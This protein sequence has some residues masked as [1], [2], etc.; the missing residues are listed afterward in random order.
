MNNQDKISY[1]TLACA[2]LLARCR[3]HTIAESLRTVPFTD[4]VGRLADQLIAGEAVS[5]EQ[6]AA[7]DVWPEPAESSEEKE[8]KKVGESE[9]APVATSDP[10]S[11][12]RGGQ[13][14]SRMGFVSEVQLQDM[15]LHCPVCGNLRTFV[16]DA[17]EVEHLQNSG[18][19]E[20]FCSYC[21]AE[22]S[23]KSDTEESE[24]ETHTIII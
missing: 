18:N 9:P 3:R 1:V 15:Q 23:W 24:E 17:S 7:Q 20:L 11:F 10:F 14:V 2:L 8:S 19:L 6:K 22:S 12:S 16:L 21:E 13:R 4:R 5:K